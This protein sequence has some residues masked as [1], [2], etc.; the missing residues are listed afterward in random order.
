MTNSGVD[1]H[2]NVRQGKFVF[3]FEVGEVDVV[4]D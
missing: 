2:V 3:Q 1:K 4:A